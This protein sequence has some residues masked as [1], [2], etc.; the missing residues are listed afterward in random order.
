[1]SELQHQKHIITLNYKRARYVL[2]NMNLIKKE[3][4]TSELSHITMYSP[5]AADVKPSKNHLDV[6]IYKGTSSVFQMNFV[7]IVGSCT[8][9]LPVPDVFKLT[10]S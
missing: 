5:K 2:I 9:P 4:K 6:L 10:L 7:D 3:R 1:M 8:N